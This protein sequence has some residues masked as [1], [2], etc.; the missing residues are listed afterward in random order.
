MHFSVLSGQ[1]YTVP[2]M[3]IANGWDDQ[4]SSMP[5]APAP[6]PTPG[7]GGTPAPAHE[8]KAY[9]FKVSVRQDGTFTVTNTRNGFSKTY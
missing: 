8:G 3:F 7:A 6:P 1:E 9:W 2:G 4:P 5:I